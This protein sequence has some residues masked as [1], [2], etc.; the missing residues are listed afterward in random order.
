MLRGTPEPSSPNVSFQLIL[1]FLNPRRIALLRDPRTLMA[2]QPEDIFKTSACLQEPYHKCVPKPVR[3][4]M[5]NALKPKQ[6][7]K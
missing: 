2:Q 6:F 3:V 7:L 1:T 4:S 5:E